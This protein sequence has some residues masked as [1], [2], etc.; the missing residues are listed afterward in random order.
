MYIVVYLSLVSPFEFR[1]H[2]IVSFH[3]LTFSLPAPSLPLS[4]LPVPPPPAPTSPSL[5]DTAEQEMGVG[6]RIFF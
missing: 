4:S 1:Y 6:F 3:S 2:F 5:R